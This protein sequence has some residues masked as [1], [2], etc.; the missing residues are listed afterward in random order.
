MPVMTWECVIVIEG[1]YA[2]GRVSLLSSPA[3][4]VV[5]NRGYGC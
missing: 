4:S 2:R 5:S 3:G 1:V